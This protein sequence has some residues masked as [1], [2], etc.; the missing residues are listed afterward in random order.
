MQNSLRRILIKEVGENMQCDKC[1]KKLS[2]FFRE[3]GL[4]VWLPNK[5]GTLCKMCYGKL[6]KEYKAK[7]TCASC[8]YFNDELCRKFDFVLTPTRFGIIYRRAQAYYLEANECGHF[9]TKNDYMKK[10]LRVR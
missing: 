3:S 5:N 6:E 10:A 2:G 7:K 1:G 4:P 8:F 9:I